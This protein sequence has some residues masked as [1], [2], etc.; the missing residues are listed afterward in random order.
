M[1]IEEMR[2][3]IKIK[4]SILMKLP[5]ISYIHNNR[6]FQSYNWNFLD[7][8]ILS[9]KFHGRDME[10]IYFFIFASCEPLM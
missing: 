7:Q 3:L 4:I 6:N 2:P 10:G 5:Q 8:P 1:Q 9:Y